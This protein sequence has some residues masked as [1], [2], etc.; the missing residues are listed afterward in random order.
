MTSRY[1]FHADMGFNVNKHGVLQG[2]FVKAL[3]H[4]EYLCKDCNMWLSGASAT[5]TDILWRALSHLD[6][7]SGV[8]DRFSS[9]YDI[10]LASP[11]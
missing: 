5:G 3:V 11:G 7:F 9:N 4:F 2:V 6:M 8:W 1:G 10:D